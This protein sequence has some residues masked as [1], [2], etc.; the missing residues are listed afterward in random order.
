MIT[1][2]ATNTCERLKNDLLHYFQTKYNFDYFFFAINNFS[3][4]TRPNVNRDLI[5]LAMYLFHISEHLDIIESF[6]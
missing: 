4:L 5:C 2:I 3:S 1:V 6:A